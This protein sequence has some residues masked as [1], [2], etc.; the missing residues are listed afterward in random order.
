MKRIKI[1]LILILIVLLFTAFKDDI[2]VFNH[3]TEQNTELYLL[4]SI[5]EKD[6]FLYAIPPTKE[7]MNYTNMTI[8]IGENE[9][10]F[11]WKDIGLPIYIKYVDSYK[12]GVLKEDLYIIFTTASGTDIAINEVHIINP[13]TMD[14]YEVDN[15]VSV[16]NDTI[17]MEFSSKEAMI[18]IDDIIYLIPVTSNPKFRYTKPAVGDTIKFGLEN[19]P[20][21]STYDRLTAD[22]GIKISPSVGIGLFKVYYTFKNNRY[23]ITN[24]EYLK[25]SYY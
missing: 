5:P 1:V 11:N 13:E 18:I 4:A 23:K 24:I 10:T 15:P 9:K 3:K 21:L 14:E 7:G 17:T 8:K 16:I 12:E 19:K 22:V 2:M 20:L 25:S 6:T